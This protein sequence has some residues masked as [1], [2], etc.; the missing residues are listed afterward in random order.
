MAFPGLFILGGLALF[1]G[2]RAVAHR[3][4][5]DNQRKSLRDQLR[6]QQAQ[7]DREARQTAARLKD[8]YGRN[9]QQGSSIF[10]N[11]EGDLNYGLQTNETN[12]RNSF[13][14]RSPN[15]G[16]F[17]FFGD[18]GSGI[19]KGAETYYNLRKTFGDK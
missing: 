13:N 11:I 2:G 18:F 15:F 19:F 16:A 7:A 3:Q 17:D 1:G 9:L 10:D 8:Y 14:S 6:A 4:A 5:V 12:Y